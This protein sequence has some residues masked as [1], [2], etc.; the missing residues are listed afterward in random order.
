MAKTTFIKMWKNMLDEGC[1]IPNLYFS[2]WE[3]DYTKE[4][5]IAVFRRIESVFNRE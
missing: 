1:K 5:L 2:A 3:E 4:L